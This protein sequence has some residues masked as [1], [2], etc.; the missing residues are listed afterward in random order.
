[1]AQTK[2][3]SQLISYSWLENGR[4][5]KQVRDVFFFPRGKYKDCQISDDG[6]LKCLL[7]GDNVPGS[8][9]SNSQWKPFNLQD[10][11]QDELAKQFS[12]NLKQFKEK[13]DVDG[14]FSDYELKKV[15]SIEI[16]RSQLVGSWNEFANPGK[17][18]EG[19]F[20]FRVKLPYPAPSSFVGVNDL[21]EW[22]ESNL[23]HVHSDEKNHRY[24]IDID[25]IKPPSPYIPHTTA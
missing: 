20:V 4:F 24:S 6:R 15:Y 22:L 10:I 8:E 16:E 18:Q 17:T 14:I 13:W 21:N 23:Y 19:Q 5:S 3:V 9:G 12:N 2:L 7:T 11:E 1:M 25:T